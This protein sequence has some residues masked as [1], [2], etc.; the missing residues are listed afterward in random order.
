MANELT[1]SVL[2]G[3]DN[4]S[5]Q[6]EAMVMKMFPAIYDAVVDKIVVESAYQGEYNT[7]FTILNGVDPQHEDSSWLKHLEDDSKLYVPNELL[8]TLHENLPRLAVGPMMAADVCSYNSPWKQELPRSIAR[9]EHAS[10]GH[11]NKGWQLP[12]WRKLLQKVAIEHGGPGLSYVSAG[13]RPHADSGFTNFTC[14]QRTVAAQESNHDPLQC[15][16][17][18]GWGSYMYYTTLERPHKATFRLIQPARSSTLMH[19]RPESQ[20]VEQDE[21]YA[22]LPEATKFLNQIWRDTEEFTPDVFSVHPSIEN[23]RI[24][25]SFF[26]KGAAN[27]RM[28]LIPVNPLIPPPFKVRIFLHSVHLKHS[29]TIPNGHATFQNKR[30]SIGPVA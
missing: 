8:S 10:G 28:L 20:S 17:D 13:L 29:K 7:T 16:Q 5:I 11:G 3:S 24:M 12:T 14:S 9:F 6:F 1:E 30:Q 2:D 15:L 25:N 19:V 27:P 23:A 21:R 18:E 22:T 4:D 26:H